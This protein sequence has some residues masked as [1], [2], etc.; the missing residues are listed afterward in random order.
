MQLCC[1]DTLFFQLLDLPSVSGIVAT[2]V[3]SNI[4]VELWSDRTYVISEL[5]LFL[6]RSELFQVPHRGIASGTEIKVE[7]DQQS[8]VYIALNVDEGRDGGLLET[9]PE[10]GWTLMT[11]EVKYEGYKGNPHRLDNIWRKTMPPETGVSFTTTTGDLTHS[12]FVS[13]GTISKQ[14]FLVHI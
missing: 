14:Y 13:E 3:D 11:G 5:P 6:E 12:I 8:F 10:Q 7:N 4:G 1:I 2:R 9:L